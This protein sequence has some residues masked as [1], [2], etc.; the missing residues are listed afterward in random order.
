MRQRLRLALAF[1]LS[2][3]PLVA[4]SAAGCGGG[5]NRFAD[6][7]AA[8]V[9]DARADGRRDGAGPT[10]GG[11]DDDA[12]DA[13]AWPDCSSKPSGVPTQTIPQIWNASYATETQVWMS[14]VFVTGVTGGGCTAGQ[15]CQIFVQDASYADIALAAKHAIKVF[16]SAATSTYFTGVR[17]GD[18]VDVLGYAWRYTLG[19]QNEN[20]VQVN[21]KLPGCF[22]KV[23]S[24]AV[25]PVTNAPLTS[26]T[27][28]AYEN[29]YGPLLVTVSDVSGRPDPTP[30]TTFGV[31]PTGAFPDGG[32]PQ[33][34]VSPSLMPGSVFSGLYTD[35][36]VARFT[37]I[38]GVFGTFVPPVD[39]GTP[40]KYAEIYPRT[41]GDIVKP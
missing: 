31:W 3:W 18:K 37:S 7:D 29:S 24:G 2:P 38:T 16:V 20:L 9:A 33:Q 27:V 4:G 21:V 19:G 34:S 30:N 22:K 10:D 40:P 36:G 23:G 6:E 39:G 25:S 5:G 13:F 17:A 35:G 1:L 12:S 41:T 11:P 26:L 28:S 15:A 14:G 8:S 32:F